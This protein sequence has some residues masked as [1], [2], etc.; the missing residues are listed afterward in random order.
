MASPRSRRSRRLSAR[1]SSR[2]A[3]PNWRSPDLPT[4]ESLSP[5]TVARV[6]A[7]HLPEGAIIVDEGVSSGHPLHPLTATAR[8]HDHLAVSG[9]AIGWA[10]A[11]ATGAAVACPGRKTICLHGD[12]GA[13]M[14]L[15]ALWTQAR[16]NLDVTTVIFSNR[17]YAI[18]DIEM[19]RAGFD[20]PA[21]AARSLFDLTRPRLD[22]VKL[23]QGMGVEASRA[24]TVA[25]FADQFASAV[26]GVGPRLIE[27]VI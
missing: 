10:L 4:G 25:A 18:L 27:A 14:T 9:G 16:E 13:M 26:G 2:P 5:A 24:E 20:G 7:R 22:W 12:G 3:S 1:R 15:Q 17:A 21:P 6:V 23:A 8:P 11:A 19:A